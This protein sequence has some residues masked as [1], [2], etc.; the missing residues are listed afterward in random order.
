M[1]EFGLSYTSSALCKRILE[2]IYCFVGASASINASARVENPYE[3]VRRLKQV[4]E[5]AVD[6]KSFLRREGRMCE[7]RILLCNRSMVCMLSNGIIC[8]KRQSKSKANGLVSRQ[9]IQKN[10]TNSQR[11]RLLVITNNSL[12]F[13]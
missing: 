3:Y 5:N 2:S 4:S 9:A 11:Y 1:G 8:H 7:R 13:H 12:F 6:S 10:R